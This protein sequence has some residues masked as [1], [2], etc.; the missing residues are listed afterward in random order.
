MLNCLATLVAHITDQSPTTIRIAGRR[1]KLRR[2]G[3]HA[4]KE[5]RMLRRV[6]KISGRTNMFARD[7]QQMQRRLWRNV[8]KGDDK[9]RG[10]VLRAWQL[11]GDDA[12]EETISHASILAQPTHPLPNDQPG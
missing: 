7:D 6:A 2:N 11:T 9:V 5:R 12:T 8:L 4:R 3:V 1:S 10:V